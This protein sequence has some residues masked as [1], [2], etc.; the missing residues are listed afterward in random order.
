MVAL[1]VGAKAL[2]S[3]RGALE[4]GEN[5]EVRTCP[6]TRLLITGKVSPELRG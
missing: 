5:K 6:S 4:E 3:F 2:R 1:T